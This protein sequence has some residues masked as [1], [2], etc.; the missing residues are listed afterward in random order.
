MYYDYLEL[1][2]DPP[3]SHD[4]VIEYIA[5]ALNT[6]YDAVHNTST[7]WTFL[8]NY[9][10]YMLRDIIFHDRKRS[11]ISYKNEIFQ[12]IPD[13]P[14]IFKSLNDLYQDEELRM[15]TSH[16]NVVLKRYIIDNEYWDHML[17]FCFDPVQNNNLLRIPQSDNGIEY[18]LQPLKNLRNE[19]DYD[20]IDSIDTFVLKHTTIINRSVVIDHNNGNPLVSESGN[21]YNDLS[22][23]YILFFNFTSDL[24]DKIIN[25]EDLNYDRSSFRQAYINALSDDNKRNE[26]SEEEEGEEEEEEEEGEEEEEEGEEEK[27]ED[28]K[29]DNKKQK[30]DKYK[31]G[32]RALKEIKKYQKSTDLLI[33]KKPFYRVVREILDEIKTK[34]RLQSS[35]VMALQEAAEAYIVGFLEDVNLCNIHAKRVTIMPHDIKLA[36]KLRGEK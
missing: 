12:N 19:I 21:V 13:N 25:F 2:K 33:P 26:N 8:C 30:I 4:V 11:L 6:L 17:G 5:I 28:N 10:R 3:P 23:I 24:I 18:F 16:M 35:A 27:K 15:N 14:F 36:Q 31:P 22:K 7:W 9:A 29:K 20:K 1:S 32:E 34:Y